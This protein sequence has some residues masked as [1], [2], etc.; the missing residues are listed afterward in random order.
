[1]RGS[2]LSFCFWRSILETN[3]AKVIESPN[4][5]QV[6]GHNVAAMKKKEEHLKRQGVYLGYALLEFTIVPIFNVT[7]S[8]ARKAEIQKKKEKQRL[9]TIGRISLK[10]DK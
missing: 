4:G 2:F 7:A 10:R 9:N 1:M 8:L 3:S 6:C 5:W